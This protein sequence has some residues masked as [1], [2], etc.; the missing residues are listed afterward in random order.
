MNHESGKANRE[1]PGPPRAE[2]V[3]TAYL[4]SGQNVVGSDGLSL[5]FPRKVVGAGCQIY[6]KNA[7]G[8]RKG[9][10]RIFAHISRRGQRVLEDASDARQWRLKLNGRRQGSVV[11]LFGWF[12]RTGFT[13]GSQS[14]C[15]TIALNIVNVVHSCR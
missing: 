1:V 12:W 6:D 3:R 8:S 15:S 13:H 9:G 7:R 10:R 5:V 14:L 2:V 4:N 11:A